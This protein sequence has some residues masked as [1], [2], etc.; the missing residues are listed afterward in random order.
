[1]KSLSHVRL[2]VTPWT[3]A[4]QVPPSMGFSGQEYWS[5]V[6]LP[7]SLCCVYFT[8]KKKTKTQQLSP[9]GPLQFLPLQ[10]RCISN[11]LYEMASCNAVIEPMSPALE[12]GVLTTGP[13]GMSWVFNLKILRL[14]CPV[15]LPGKSHGWRNLVGYSPWGR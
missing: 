1:M 7:S 2:F 11:C 15:L 8:T 14:H 6:P 9:T 12:D 5:G 13:P 3:V 10:F 4:Y